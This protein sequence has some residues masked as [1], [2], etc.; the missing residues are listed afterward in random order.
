MVVFGKRWLYSG[1]SACIG[2]KVVVFGQK[3]LYSGKSGCVRKSEYIRAM[4]LKAG[5]VIVFG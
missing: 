4:C 2:E 1:K 5:K 3:W